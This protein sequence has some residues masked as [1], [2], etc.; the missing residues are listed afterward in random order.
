VATLWRITEPDHCPRR[1][2][3]GEEEERRGQRS[4]GTGLLGLGIQS[5]LASVVW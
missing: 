4:I 1:G 2:E 5:L 3:G